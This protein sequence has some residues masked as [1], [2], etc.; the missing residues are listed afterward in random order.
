M[1]MQ[2]IDSSASYADL[3]RAFT[4]VIPERFNIGVA[5]SDAR[6]PG[7]AGQ[8]AIV[9]V[10]PAGVET[11]DFASLARLTDRLAAALQDDGVMRGDR[12][13][14]LLPQGRDV[15]IAHLAVYKAGAI[16]VPL[17]H[18]F[19]ADALEY[20][21]MDCGASA[22]VTDL[23]GCEKLDAVLSRTRLPKLRII[24]SNEPHTRANRLLSTLLE[25]PAEDFK[26]EPTGP[27]DPCLMI[28][29]SG[30]TGQPKGT[31]HGHRVL[32][33]H[34]PGFQF[35]HRPFEGE[36]TLFWTPADWAWA[37]GLLN[38]LLPALYFGKPVLAWPYRKFD[39]GAAFALM[40]RHRISHAFIPP[41]ALRMMR[42]VKGPSG[43]YPL[44]L[45]RVASAGEA[46][47]AET[48]HWAKTALGVPVDEFYGQTECNYILGSSHHRDVS[49]AGA[50]GKALPG[51]EVR[52]HD[53]DGKDCL[54]GSTGQI[55]IGRDHPSMFLEYW[56]RADAT[57]A[58]FRDGW[59][60]TGDLATIDKEGYIAFTGR[61]DDIITSSGYRIGPVEIE[62]CL[63]QHRAVALAAV[64]GKPD[65][66]RTEIV[67]A[68]LV[69]KPGVDPSPALVAE[70][71]DFVRNRL[72]VYEYPREIAFVETLPM[73]TTGK[74]M[75]RVLRDLG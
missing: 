16:A 31:L 47:G 60:L 73:T 21:L 40:E 33:G 15:A 8:T 54:P 42:A 38:L 45:R 71:Q 10:S 75:R 61:D 19:R 3:M 67:K 29:T 20:R 70:I 52:V 26:A 7:D 49:K 62:D 11:L 14:I 43:R 37:G 63:L 4:W 27:D 6:L 28:Y 36:D 65:A 5:C 30:T 23:D 24:A 56:G 74:I 44:A 39:P 50:I 66:L 69:L 48:Y 25:R 34:L 72:S 51:A 13:A 18:A 53:A 22:I 55:V 58:K 2:D 17:A 41:T 35:S 9:D 46:L 64:I 68:F 1:P 12:V 57:E 59:M 32:L